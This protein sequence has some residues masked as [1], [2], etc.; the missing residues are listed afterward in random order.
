MN[1]QSNTRERDLDQLH[2]SDAPSEG[3][4]WPGARKNNM[5]RSQKLYL[6]WNSFNTCIEKGVRE[7]RSML[8]QHCIILH[9]M[10]SECSGRNYD[11]SSVMTDQISNLTVQSFPEICR[12]DQSLNETIWTLKCD[13]LHMFDMVDEMKRKS[14]LI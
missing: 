13:R 6:Y 14:L 3:Q 2:F 11:W 10:F 9:H 5:P 4:V 12:N 8:T 7:Y 1:I